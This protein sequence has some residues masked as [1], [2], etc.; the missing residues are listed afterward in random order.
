MFWP[1]GVGLL[2]KILFV[3][4]GEYRIHMHRQLWIERGI[5]A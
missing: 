2:E 4:G 5:T 3:G 1:K